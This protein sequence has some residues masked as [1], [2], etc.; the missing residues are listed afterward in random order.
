ML[1]IAASAL[2]FA[3]MASAAH[4]QSPAAQQS[5]E[6]AG[7]GGPEVEE[8]IVTADR[9]AQDVTDVPLAVSA[10]TGAFLEEVGAV[11]L[12]DIARYTPNLIATWDLNPAFS[13]VAI[14][15]LA[16][17][18]NN[19]GIDPS[20]G[21]FIDGVYMGR[22]ELYTTELTDIQR[23]EVLRGPQGTLYGKNTS[24]GAIN[25]ITRKPAFGAPEGQA[26]V[27]IG[28]Y[29]LRRFAGYASFPLGERAAVMISLLNQGR[30]GYTVNT[31]NGEDLNFLDTQAVRLKLRFQ[32]SDTLELNFSVDGLQD[33]AGGNT[34]G[35]FAPPGGDPI[36]PVIA[37]VGGN[38]EGVFSRR[39]THSPGQF[40]N[41]DVFGASLEATLDIGELTLT[42]ITGYREFTFD[43]RF[44]FDATPQPY[45]FVGKLDNQSQISQEL[46]LASPDDGS[47]S[48]IVGA[49]YFRSQL[50]SLNRVDIDT[51]SG[52]GQIVDLR[53]R[54]YDLETTSYALFGQG[55][56]RPSDALTLTL[57]LRYTQEEKDLVTSQFSSF[58]LFG[59]FPLVPQLG[60]QSLSRSEN[61]VSPRL[62]AT[63]AFTDDLT[64]YATYARGYKSGGFNA[65]ILD[66][67]DDFD[68]TAFDAE[69]GDSLEF[70]LKGYLM[71]RRARFSVSGFLTRFED[72][73]TSD[74]NGVELVVRNAAE[75]QTY[76]IESEIEFKVTDSLDVFASLG[77]NPTEYRNAVG[78]NVPE[79]A[80]TS[81]TRDLSGL[82]LSRA[83]EWNGTIVASYRRQ[84]PG[85]SLVFAATADYAFV[86]EHFLGAEIDPRSK[87]DGYGLWN[88]RV[89]LETAD[90]R[91]R[92]SLW[93]KNL[94]DEDYLTAVGAPSLP[95]AF[96]P[97]GPLGRIGWAGAP[98]AWGIELTYQY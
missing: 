28:D 78:A 81:P 4:A 59:T 21:V 19:V 69:V 12:D 15:G 64:A 11:D 84:I 9:R 70:G 29:R 92:F 80:G 37:A 91:V 52:F 42:S 65:A 33:S 45:L 55:S 3:T 1:R 83:P 30:D 23:V 54:P 27:T 63:Y 13:V 95:S 96:D 77:W 57:G 53:R 5:G 50:D 25:I 35:Y 71:D 82:P 17:N 93:G 44:D 74:F 90:S 7:S 31:V 85:L 18:S 73:Q 51:P 86:S 62:S 24:V 49:Y 94:A 79:D 98:R 41:R 39:V 22:P 14:R 16:S 8:I 67:A 60:A 47:F 2:A 89:G 68:G 36:P 97:D 61:D 58:R 10:F 76:G 32:P 87:Q 56:W 40:N 26:S 34:A 6:T 38:T 66:A 20:V 43:S 46:R 88:A 75:A 48:Y 72:L